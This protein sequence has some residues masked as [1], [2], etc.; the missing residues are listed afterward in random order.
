MKC[1]ANH[2]CVLTRVLSYTVHNCVPVNFVV[3]TYMRILGS[4]Q[5]MCEVGGS[6]VHV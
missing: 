4:W 5:Y 3:H 1:I 6:A 2:E